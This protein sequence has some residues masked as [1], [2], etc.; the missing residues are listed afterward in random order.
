MKV[1]VLGPGLIGCRFP[2]HEVRAVRHQPVLVTRDIAVQAGFRHGGYAVRQ[3]GD[4][5]REMVV[6]AVQVVD[7]A[8]PGS[9]VDQLSTSDS[10]K[11]VLGPRNLP[12]VSPVI[13][14]ALRHADA[15]TPV[16]RD[17]RRR[18][19]ADDRIVGAALLATA[20]RTPPKRLALNDAAPAIF[21][22]P[23]GNG[24]A[25]RTLDVGGVASLLRTV[26]GINPDV[27]FCRPVTRPHT[28]LRRPGDGLLAVGDAADNVPGLW[29]A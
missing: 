28:A 11:G 25:P 14:S 5:V 6:A 23:A 10:V 27:A 9:V 18:L 1:T 3:Q 8:D 15:V 13:A 22:V 24:G 2:R 19:A 4:T 26:S 20:A 21:Q 29:A 16:G 17:L 7:A 12:E